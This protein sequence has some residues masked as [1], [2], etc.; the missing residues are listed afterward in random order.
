[1]ANISLNGSMRILYLSFI[2]SLISFTSFS[3]GFTVNGT[4]KSSGKLMMQSVTVSLKNTNH[5]AVTGEDGN[6]RIADVP[7]GDYLLVVSHL[8]FR[9][10]EQN[11]RIDGKPVFVEIVLTESATE[12]NEV[13][14]KTEK[15]TRILET[16]PIAISSIEIKNVISQNVLITDVVDRLS[17][18]RIRRSSSLGDNSDISIN[19]MRGNAVRIYVDGLPME[20]IYPN[21]DISTLPIGNLKRIDV[22][23]GVLPVDVGTDALGGGINLITE[24]K[25]FNSLKASYNVG[26]FNTHLA[27]F[28]LGLANAKN[29]FMSVSGAYHYSDND[30]Q[31]DA[32]IFEQNNKTERVR[33]FHDRY[34]MAFGS[35]TA[36]THSKPWADELKLTLNLSGGDKQLQNGARVTGF[37]FGEANYTAQNLSAILKYDKSFSGEKGLFTTTVN[38]SD[39]TLGYVD[40][41]RNVYSWSGAIVGRQGSRGEYYLANSET[42]IKSWVNRTSLSFKLAANHKLLF[43]NLYAKQ[44]LTGI[45]YL[46][47]NPAEDYLRVPQYLS[48]NVAGIQYEGLYLRRMTFSTALKRFDYILDGAENNTF[49]LIKKKGG[50]WGY[51]A[52]LK[53]DITEGIFARASYEKGFLI[54]LFYQFVGNGADIIRNTDLLPESSDNLN[55]GFSLAK[56]VNK[57]INISSTV[58][59][60]YRNQHDIIFIGSGVIRRYDNADQVRTV[61][62]EGDISLTYKTAFSW[63]TNV[64][65]LRKTFTKVLVADSQFLVGTDFPNNP[66]FYANSEFSWQ[67]G[68][69]VKTDDRFRAYLF[70]N[71]ITAFNHITIGKENSQE[72]TP[73]AYVPVQHRL[74]AGFSYKFPKRALTASL[75]VLNVFNAKLF[76]NYL[77][78]RAGINF[79]VKVIYELTNF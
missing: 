9:T 76:D 4:V 20:F 71:Y 40:T 14:V 36:G 19:G 59:G 11:I 24:Q 49:Q 41:T 12:L 3:Q 17:G 18:V 38:Y 62:V 53:Y 55:L 68:G 15:Q 56:P 21:F 46:E 7:N 27:D 13:L 1:L 2:I 79:N 43:S 72:N 77:V 39:Q 48:K 5:S 28:T 78:P 52:A 57:L 29:Y 32:P 34:R 45:D 26:S 37:A 10:F 75:N 54:P 44:K 30:Y 58:N 22:Y 74:D 61:G 8:G 6:F 31:M 60:F 67:K 33:R 51:N 65:F 47:Q 66:N 42:Y 69:L 50:I 73:E 23:K 64:T 70:Y 16:K 25:S 63:K 35:I